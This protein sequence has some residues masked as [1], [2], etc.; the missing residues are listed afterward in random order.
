M[1]VVAGAPVE[2]AEEKAAPPAASLPDPLGAPRAAS[3]P[4]DD[5]EQAASAVAVS[6]AH[7][8]LLMSLPDCKAYARVSDWPMCRAFPTFPPPAGELVAEIG[9]LV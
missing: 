2:P 5:E 8:P 4:D 6:S 1:G 9:T 3:K 7:D